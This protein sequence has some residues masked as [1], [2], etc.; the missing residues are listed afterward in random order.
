MEIVLGVGLNVAGKRGI[1]HFIE[2]LVEWLAELDD[3]DRF[4]VFSYFFGGHAA[5][6]ARLPCPDKPNWSRR[7]PRVPERLVRALEARGVPVVQSLLLGPK[8]ALYH[9][10]DGVLPRLSGVRTLT[11]IYDLCFEHGRAPGDWAHPAYRETCLRSD[12]LIAVSEATKRDLVAI[13]G[14]DPARVEVIPTGVNPRKLRPAD[15]PAVRARYG[16]PAR[17]VVL[18]GPFEPRRNA[19]A[20]LAA[21]AAIGAESSDFALALVGSD[22][23]YRRGLEEKARA[24]G[25]GGRLVACGYVADADLPAVFSGA[26]ALVH[27]TRGE[28]FGTVSLEAMACGCPVITSD[29]P[30]VVEA[31]AE[32]AFTVGCDDVAALAA[33]LK[34]LALDPAARAARREAGLKRAALFTYDKI[35]AR[36]LALYERLGRQ[37]S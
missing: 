28:G 27:P 4:T 30:P 12:A 37:E 33:R 17:Y 32:A 6:A 9:S 8:P 14:V 23:A 29:I 15:D 20:V 24:L 36:T 21:A 3:R 26:L 11:T 7:V 31:V 35:A 10:L 16:L 13:Y 18:L 19:E 2:N 25:L 5:K 1:D 34:S 22:S